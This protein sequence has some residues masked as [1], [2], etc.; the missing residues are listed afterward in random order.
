MIF[1]SDIPIDSF[2]KQ[3]DRLGIDYRYD[4]NFGFWI[5]SCHYILKETGNLTFSTLGF[6]YTIPVFNGILLSSETMISKFSLSP[7][8]FRNRYTIFHL[9]IPINHINNLAF[10][11]FYDWDDYETN[12]NIVRWSTTYDSFN[13]DYMFTLEPGRFND[14]F[15]IMFIYNH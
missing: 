14:N 3:N 10:Y 6:D 12:N 1:T 9:S 7:I 4:G 11:S 8:A 15:Q 2:I 13:I 5:E